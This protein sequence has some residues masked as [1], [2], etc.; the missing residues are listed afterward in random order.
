MPLFSRRSAP[1]QL[2]AAPV[3]RDLFLLDLSPQPPKSGAWMGITGKGP[4]RGACPR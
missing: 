1:P 2:E 4:G 3:Q